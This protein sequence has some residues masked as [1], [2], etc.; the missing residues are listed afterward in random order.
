LMKLEQGDGPWGACI[1]VRT[2]EGGKLEGIRV[3]TSQN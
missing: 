1:R 3:S 2:P